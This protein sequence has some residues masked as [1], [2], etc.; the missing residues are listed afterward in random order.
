VGTAAYLAP[1]QAR[2]E[3]ATPAADVYALG[4]VVYQLLTGRLPWEGSTLAE[5]SIR[6]ENERPLPPSSYDPEVPEQLSTA[7]LRALEG[8]VAARYGTARELSAALRAGIA[9]AEPPVASGEAPTRA[10]AAG[11]AATRAMT[12]DSPTP[13]SEQRPVARPAPPPRAVARPAEAR[14]RR[15]FMGHLMR[16]LGLLLLIGILAA[17]IAGVVLLVTDAGQNTDVGDFVKDQLNE[18]IDALRD[19]I[20][21]QTQ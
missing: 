19:F 13:V 11:T 12:D 6:R 17:V 7:V 4:V 20:E 16:V 8:D 10:L 3:E 21:Q 14:P 5:L 2:G 15:S 1:E 9:G 18:Q